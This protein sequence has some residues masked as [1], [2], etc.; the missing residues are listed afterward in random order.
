M[1][2]PAKHTAVTHSINFAVKN[3]ANINLLGNQNRLWLLKFHFLQ[4]F[5]VVSVVFIKYHV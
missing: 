1:V 3:I 4:F 2:A 5:A